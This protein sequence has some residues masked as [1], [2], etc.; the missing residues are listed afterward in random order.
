[1]RKSPRA[2]LREPKSRSGKPL[3]RGGGRKRFLSRATGGSRRVQTK[4]EIESLLASWLVLCDDDTGQETPDLAE[5]LEGLLLPSNDVG[6]AGRASAPALWPATRQLILDRELRHLALTDDLTCLY[7]RRG[8]FAA[9]T[10]GLK[11]ARWSMQE[12]TLF[13]CDVKNLKQ[14]NELFGREEGDF[15]LV[16]TADALEEAFRDSD[17]LA[18]LGGD[19]FAVLASGAS[20]VHQDAVLSRLESCL[21]RANATEP[22]YPLSLSVGAAQFDPHHPSKLSE[23]MELAERAMNER[24]QRQSYSLP[25]E[26]GSD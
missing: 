9:A 13:C 21:Q 15:A 10:Q 8:F 24:K 14:I 17:L 12:M 1:M 4:T 2:R 11:F 18:R 5:L 7:N 25:L 26:L 16:R 22:R 23:L 6:I 20:G 19:E 3:S